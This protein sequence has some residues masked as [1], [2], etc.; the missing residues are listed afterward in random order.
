[1]R[2]AARRTPSPQAM[3]ARVTEHHADEVLTEMARD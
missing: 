1:M 3:N 2:L